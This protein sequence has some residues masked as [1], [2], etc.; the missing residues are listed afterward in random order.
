MAEGAIATFGH[1]K[2]LPLNRSIIF[3]F[4]M[5]LSFNYMALLLSMFALL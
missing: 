1:N 5:M 3:S 4:V 2:A